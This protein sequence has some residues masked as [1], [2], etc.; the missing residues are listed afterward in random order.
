MTSELILAPQ[1]EAE[2]AEARD[3]YDARRPGLGADFLVAVRIAFAAIAENP[4]QY[5]VSCK[6]FRRAGLGR[7]PYTL[8][9]AYRLMQSEW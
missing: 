1:A 2:I 4:H 7:F 3:W 5:Q 6:H 8:I 9:T